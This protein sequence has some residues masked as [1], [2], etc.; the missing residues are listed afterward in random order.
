MTNYHV[1]STG[2]KEQMV[3]VACIILSG[4]SILKASLVSSSAL[5]KGLG[6]FLNVKDHNTEADAQASRTG[7][8]EGVYY[9]D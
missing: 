9:Y 5:T 1:L 4:L 3:E 2:N 8:V 6:P 7:Q